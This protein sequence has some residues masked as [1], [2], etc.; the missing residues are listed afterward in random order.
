MISDGFTKEE[1]TQLISLVDRIQPIISPE[2]FNS[3]L[4]KFVLVAIETVILRQNDDKIE[5]LLTKRDP[6]DEFYANQWHSPGSI[7]RYSDVHTKG[8]SIE[9]ELTE[10]FER[11]EKK[12]IGAP[13]RNPPKF[14]EQR[15][16]DFSRGPNLCLVHAA[17]IAP[18]ASYNGEFFDVNN[19]PNDPVIHQQ[20]PF[21]RSAIRFFI[22]NKARKV[23]I[24]KHQLSLL[25][26]L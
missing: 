4:S 9:S 12:E 23:K 15:L 25:Q 10:V 20:M 16:L 22:E 13:F 6:N 11:I 1:E 5:V 26:L 19:L 17:Q 21:L 7:L 8:K 24:S 14:I 18:R 2:L 3:V